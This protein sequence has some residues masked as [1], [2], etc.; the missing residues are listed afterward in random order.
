DKLFGIAQPLQTFLN[1]QNPRA[2][3]SVC[4][5]VPFLAPHLLLFQLRVLN[6]SD[7]RRA[8][9]TIPNYVLVDPHYPVSHCYLLL[10]SRSAEC[11]ECPFFF[12]DAKESIGDSVRHVVN[13]YQL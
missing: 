7:L 11:L 4:Y 8:S 1:Q 12:I 2:N 13:T 3:R 6:E 10:L 9:E 5:G